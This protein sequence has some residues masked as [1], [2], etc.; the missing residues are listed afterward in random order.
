MQ[1]LFQD[2]ELGSI[3]DVGM[4]GP[5]VWASFA[6]NHD[7]A[8]FV[9]MWKFITDEDTCDLD[10][11]FPADFLDDE[12]W[13]VLEDGGVKRGIYLPAVYDDGTISWHWRD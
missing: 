8:R 2:T 6:P 13:S 10:P 5:E 7:S 3:S 11:P 12:N 9:E 4:D 1:L